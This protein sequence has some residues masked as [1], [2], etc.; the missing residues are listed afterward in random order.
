VLQGLLIKLERNVNGPD[1]GDSVPV[2]VLRFFDALIR[3]RAPMHRVVQATAAWLDRAVAVRYVDTVIAVD[4]RGHL[5]DLWPQVITSLTLTPEIVVGLGAPA[6]Q[7]DQVLLDRLGLC[8]L[9]A[10]DEARRHGL[11]MSE[12]RAVEVLTTASESRTALRRATERLDL[13]LESAIQI[14]VASGPQSGI[15]ELIVAVQRNGGRVLSS[16]RG[17]LVVLVI[18]GT[19][20]RQVLQEGVPGGL[21]LG[22]SREMPAA[23]AP[24]AFAEALASF[25]FSQ[26]S[27]RDRGPYLIEEGVAVEYWRLG[28]YEALAEGMTPE[29]IN[30]IRDVR[31]L[32][33]V[34]DVGGPEMRRTLDVVAAASSVR[35]AARWLE[36]H[37]NTVAH[38]MAVAEQ[39]LGFSMTDAYGRGR[40]YLAIVLRRLRESHALM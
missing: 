30:R 12:Q 7:Q 18:V 3:D 21:Q 14:L 13:S 24:S 4:D 23:E 33:R 9:L 17:Q 32:D 20:V 29:L 11:M 39:T 19:R 38:R 8:V 1:A 22:L 15:A 37:H 26:P 25:R 2:S 28:G 16:T 6:G 31:S 35:Q 10:L 27:P 36:T 34:L 40:L 5:S